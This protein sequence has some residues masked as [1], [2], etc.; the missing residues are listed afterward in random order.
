MSSKNDDFFSKKIQ[1]YLTDR[2]YLHKC[3]IYLQ[4]SSFYPKIQQIFGIK[5]QLLTISQQIKTT[6]VKQNNSNSYTLKNTKNCNSFHQKMMTFS[7][8]KMT[9]DSLYTI[10]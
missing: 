7:P 4:Y 6:T 1:T 8:Q 2:T 3:Y 5:Y 9:D 10:A